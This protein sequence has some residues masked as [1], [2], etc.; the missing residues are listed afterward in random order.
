MFFISIRPVLKKVEYLV[1]T[2]VLTIWLS[3]DSNI[4]VEIDKNHKITKFK[5]SQDMK[6]P[7]TTSQLE[8]GNIQI[9]ITYDSGKATII[10][11]KKNYS[12]TTTQE[13]GRNVES[14][15]INSNG[16]TTSYESSLILD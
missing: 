14:K 1:A 16:I 8:N 15:T 7:Y 4:V 13:S 10:Y 5:H 11:D 6:M 9:E 3:G 2:K 12:I